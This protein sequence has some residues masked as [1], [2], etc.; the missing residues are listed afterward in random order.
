MSG[1]PITF[2]DEINAEIR[3]DID[4]LNKKQTI[5]NQILRRIEKL[6]KEAG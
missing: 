2:G 4:E 6:L 3:D 5:T 1:K